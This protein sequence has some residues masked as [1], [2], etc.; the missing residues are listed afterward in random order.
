M[1]PLTTNSVWSPRWTVWRTFLMVED[2]ISAAAPARLSTLRT[3]CTEEEETANKAPPTRN[4]I[5]CSD[6]TAG[7]FA[8]G[9]RRILANSCGHG[10]SDGDHAFFN[11]G[12]N[13]V[14]GEDFIDG[15]CFDGL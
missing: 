14:E 8:L 13:V 4:K 2:F 1:V 6:F 12:I 9:A 5:I 3:S 15:T 7:A 11:G 10:A